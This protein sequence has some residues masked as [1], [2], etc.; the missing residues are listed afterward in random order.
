MAVT[1]FDGRTIPYNEMTHQHL[2]NWYWYNK[3]I[4][5]NKP[6]A[7]QPLMDEIEER[8]DGEILNYRP[9]K[10]FYSEIGFLFSKGYLKPTG[11]IYYEGEKIG[12]LQKEE[13][14]K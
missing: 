3:I 5:G 12:E 14:G 4:L 7:I 11:E 13:D 6:E 1:T 2:S 10:K 9:H 8:F